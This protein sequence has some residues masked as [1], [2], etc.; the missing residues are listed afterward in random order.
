MS[1][2]VSLNNTIM[3]SIP[4]T[5]R[6]CDCQRIFAFAHKKHKNQSVVIF[7]VLSLCDTL[8][9][10]DYDPQNSEILFLI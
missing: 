2:M 4:L 7:H 6:K 5:K 1:E 3:S 9:S 10:E 8:F